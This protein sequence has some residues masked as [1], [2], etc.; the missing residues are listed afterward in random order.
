MTAYLDPPG[1]NQLPRLFCFHHAGGG[2]SLFRNWQRALSPHASVWPVLLPG[3]EHRMR[4]PRFVSLDPLIE[5]LDRELGPYLTVPHLFFGHSM[6][7]LL[8]YRL[9]CYRV[10]RGDAG[11]RALFVSAYSAP[12]LPSPFPV[13]GDVDDDR[14][15]QLLDGIGGLPDDLPPQWRAELL[16]VFRD[17][18]RVC[19]SQSETGA[20]PLTCPIHLFGADGDPL[21]D[22]DDLGAWDRHTSGPTN[23]RILHGEHFYLR[24]SPADLLNELRPLLRGYAA[25]AERPTAAPC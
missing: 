6:G 5:D 7:A 17:D 2:A 11:P 4:E 3:R 14:L 19:A 25:T 24:D 10:A 23:V 13:T 21:V 22:A 1:G 12:H 16:A 18:M 8:A 20:S 15:T 9:A